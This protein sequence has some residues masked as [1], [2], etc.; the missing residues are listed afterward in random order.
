MN[1][2]HVARH[3]GAPTRQRYVPHRVPQNPSQSASATL[4]ESAF[5]ERFRVAGQAHSRASCGISARAPCSTAERRQAGRRP[6]PG[7]GVKLLRS[8]PTARRQIDARRGPNTRTRLPA[9]SAHG[10]WG[11]ATR[12]TSELAHALP[13][14]R[15]QHAVPPRHAAEEEIGEFDEILVGRIAWRPCDGRHAAHQH[16]QPSGLL[17]RTARAEADAE[18]NELLMRFHPR[19]ISRPRLCQPPPRPPGALSTPPGT[20]PRPPRP[21]RQPPRAGRRSCPSLRGG[22]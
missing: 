8:P 15:R 6:S 14:V 19:R 10:A 9:H 13:A 12:R 2:R 7:R 20:P 18:L 16:N 11:R 5:R 17:T 21:C 4:R 3:P 1:Q 22:A